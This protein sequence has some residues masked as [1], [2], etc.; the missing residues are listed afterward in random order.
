MVAGRAGP[1]RKPRAIW[2]MGAQ[3]AARPSTEQCVL[4]GCDFSYDRHLSNACG[5][6][7]ARLSCRHGGSIRAGAVRPPGSASP[8]QSSIT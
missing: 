5:V 3:A 7:L 4:R 2:P 8:P 6:A 1:E